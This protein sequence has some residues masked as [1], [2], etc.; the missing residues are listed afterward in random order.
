MAPFIALAPG[1]S[2]RNDINGA[3][4]IPGTFRTAS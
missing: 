2:A 1:M 4:V 3:I